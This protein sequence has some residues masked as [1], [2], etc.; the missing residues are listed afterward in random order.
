MRRLQAAVPKAAA[1]PPPGGDDADDVLEELERAAAGFRA[2]DEPVGDAARL[3]P[4]EDYDNEDE[5]AAVVL[6]LL[7]EEHKAICTEVGLKE[8]DGVPCTK[9]TSKDGCRHCRHWRAVRYWRNLETGGKAAEGYR[10]AACSLARLK[11]NA[12]KEICDTLELN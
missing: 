4:L 3:R 9:C 2:G 8:Q 10:K 6:E 7:S 5:W 1:D 11:G 12:S